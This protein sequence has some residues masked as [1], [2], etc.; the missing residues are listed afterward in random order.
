L[1]PCPE[2][3]LPVLPAHDPTH[4]ATVLWVL[5]GAAILGFL[6][7]DAVIAWRRRPTMSHTSQDWFRGKPALAA[8]LIGALA[9][10]GWHLTHRL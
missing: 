3:L 7:A 9:L 6:I 2:E 10:L 1:P 8:L 4:A 5:V